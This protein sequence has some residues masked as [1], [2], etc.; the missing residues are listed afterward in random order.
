MEPSDAKRLW[1]L[2]PENAR[3]EK[4][5]ADSM[6]D[7]S[8]LR[9][10]LEKNFR[11]PVRGSTPASW[12]IKDEGC[13]RRRAC[14]LIGMAPKTFRYVSRRPN[15]AQL[16]DRSKTLAD[17]RRRLGH[18]S[19]GRRLRGNRLPAKGC[20]CRGVGISGGRPASSATR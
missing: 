11:R 19:A 3:L 6:L 14:G 16:R 13:S 15:D 7:V 17:D 2:A 10:M 8:T 4:L 1:S 20:R 18:F 9:E 12:A 5:L